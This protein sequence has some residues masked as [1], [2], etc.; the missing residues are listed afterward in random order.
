MRSKWKCIELALGITK[1]TLDQFS[2]EDDPYLETLSYWLEHGSSVTWKTL[3]DVL[4]HFETK[5]TVDVLTA[6]IVS[7]LG[8]GDQV[9][10]CC[11]LS[12]GAVWCGVW[13]RQVLVSYDLC[14]CLCWPSFLLLSPVPLQLPNPS[15]S[16]GDMEETSTE[17]TAQLSWTPAKRRR[18]SD[19]Q[20]TKS[21]LVWRSF[22]PSC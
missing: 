5:H 2:N 1:S 15:A 14:L 9:S 13:R 10:V 3:L 16:T 21:V 6:K 12:E 19:A 7:G 18:T 22:V 17:K 8:G 11:V 4:G 20:G